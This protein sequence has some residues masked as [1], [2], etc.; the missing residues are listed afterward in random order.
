MEYPTLQ[1][2]EKIQRDNFPIVKR[3]VLLTCD[4]RDEKSRSQLPWNVF[5]EYTASAELRQAIHFEFN[6]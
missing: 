6:E 1:E 3:T 4:P 5:L 2:L